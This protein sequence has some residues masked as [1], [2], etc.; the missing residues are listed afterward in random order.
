MTSAIKSR[1]LTATEIEAFGARMDAI[2]EAARKDLGE[3]DEKHIRTMLRIQRGSEIAGRTLL[4]AGI[5]PPAWVAGTTL[6]S[7]SKILENM[8]IGHNVMHGQYDFLGDPTL[9]GNTYEWDTACSGDQWRHSHNFVHH[10]YTNVVGKDRDVGYGVLRVTDEQP[11]HPIYLFQSFHAVVLM[12]LFQWGVALHDLETE[13]LRSGE[14]SVAQVWKEFRLVAKKGGKQ[15]LKDYV[16]FPALAGPFFLPVLLGNVTANLARNVWSFLIIFC[17]H[18]TEGVAM[19]DERVLEGETRGAWYLRQLGG[20]SNLEGNQAMH[21]LS[22]HLSHQ[23]EHHLFPDIPAH[24]YPEMA[25][26]VRK[27]A[28][29]Y[30]Q[31]YETGGFGAQLLTVAKRIFVHSFPSR[32]RS[33]ALA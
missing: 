16:L 6:L 12:L 13:K 29:E 23:I 17:G 18:F 14:K 10:T 11:W 4:F 5:F 25:I 8:E 32:A 19:F 21:L 22:G 1:V 24:R 3:R 27:V 7:F 33:A 9:R 2:R 31:H 26:E 15:I 30:G 20:S 28:A